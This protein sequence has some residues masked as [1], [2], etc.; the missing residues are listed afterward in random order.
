MGKERGQSAV[1]AVKFREPLEIHI[2][3]QI[4]VQQKE[5]IP[6]HIPQMEERAAASQ[7]L[8]FHK[9][10]DLYAERRPRRGGNPGP[11]TEI[12]D[13]FLALT[14][15]CQNNID[16][17]LFAQTRDL[18]FQHGDA[19]EGKERLWQTA[20]NRGNPRSASSGHNDRLQAASLPFRHMIKN[21]A[22]RLL[23]GERN[24]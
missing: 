13:N 3:N 11:A 5:I 18:A 15:D 14:A 16:N 22:S 10:A 4:A 2:E 19:V 23:K 12:A 17:P 8:I 21:L 1:R 24:L 6:E 20:G 7:R 9:I